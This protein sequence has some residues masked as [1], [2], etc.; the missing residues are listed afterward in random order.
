MK[1][2]IFIAFCL[3]SFLGFSLPAQAWDVTAK[4]VTIE[5]SYMPDQILF[6]LDAVAG[7][8]PAFN[9]MYYTGTAYASSDA[10][11]NVQAIYAGLLT[12]LSSGKRLEVHGDTNC[13]AINI[14]PT[15]QQ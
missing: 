10:T 9:W 15:N 3:A 11:K 7:T 13:V 6:K 14:H 5:P 4:V 12:A 8:C 1:P 2:S